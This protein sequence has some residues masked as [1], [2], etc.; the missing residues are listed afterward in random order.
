MPSPIQTRNNQSPLRMPQWARVL[1]EHQWRYISVRGGRGSGKTKN[2]ARALVLLSAQMPLRVLCTREVQ[3]SIRDSV[4]ATIVN[5][6]RELGLTEQ[7][8]I[9]SNEI[10]SRKWGGLFLFRGLAS[11][12]IDSIK[13]MADIDIAWVEEAQSVSRKSYDLL[14]PTI[15]G[16]GLYGNSQIW[17]SWNPILETD[18]IYELVLKEG[19]P[20]CASLFVN[21]DQNP[22]FPRVLRLEEQHMLAHNPVKHKHVWLGYPLPAVEGAIYFDE[23]MEMEREN[24]I[25]LLSR[26]D[27]LQPYAVF[28]LG[29]NDFMS[30]GIVQRT[31]MD[32]RVIDFIE[33]QRVSLGWFD[34]ELRARG[35]EGATVCFPH[36]GAH[37]SV[38]TGK[39]SQ[40]IMQD[41]GWV[42][43]IVDNM[44]VEAGIRL[45]RELMSTMFIDKFRCS[46]LVEHLKRYKRNK[47]GH[48]DHDD[49]SHASDMVRYVA[50]HANLMDTSFHGGEWGAS[51]WGKELDYPR[52]T[53]G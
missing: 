33:N 25:R 28:D 32:I 20:E 10:R 49:H 52:I 6:I 4:Y 34:T 7:F 21:F 23:I 18:P 3:L 11:E 47:H 26:D 13:S 19:L 35:Y 5:E 27:L 29:F 42:T 45:C 38:Q 8:E 31:V 41:Y 48:P 39:S 37:H 1:F 36:D 44:G 30:C 43:E 14:F 15:R 9:L 22:W 24:R 40:E 53:T 2:F 12:T 16:S 46:E 17:F 50:V 51:N